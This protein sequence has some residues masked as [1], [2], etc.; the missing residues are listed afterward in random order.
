[1]IVYEEEGGGCTVAA[2]DPE[3]MMGLTANEAL[4]PVATEAKARLERALAAVEA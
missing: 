2:L 3:N 1:V 4:K